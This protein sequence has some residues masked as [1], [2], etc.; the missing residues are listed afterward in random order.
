ML[1]VWADI[2]G[3]ADVLSAYFPYIFYI[4]VL[5][6]L[7]TTLNI[8]IMVVNRKQIFVLVLISGWVRL[9]KCLKGRDPRSS[10]K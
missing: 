7:Q 6:Y 9:S 2:C 5:V 1:V 8:K 3:Y 10:Y 4:R